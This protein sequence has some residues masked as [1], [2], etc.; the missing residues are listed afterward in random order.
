MLVIE[1][2]YQGTALATERLA[3]KFEH[4]S[5]SRLR[6]TL[7]SGVEASLFL[8]RGILL[9]G[10]DTLQAND[11]T[12]VEIVSAD[13]NLLEACC[14]THLELARAAYHLGNRHVA[15]QIGSSDNGHWLRIQDDHVLQHMLEGLGATVRSLR[16]P[17]EPEAGAYAH[18]HHHVEQG[19]TGARIHVMGGIV[20]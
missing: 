18:G 5:K 4:R 15:V 10:G 17:F 16:A 11:G 20:G 19:D 3:L 7:E 1:T 14:A 2:P 12:V 9:R 6:V 13:E 8:P